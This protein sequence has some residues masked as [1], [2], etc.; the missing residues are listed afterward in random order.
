MVSSISFV[1]KLDRGSFRLCSDEVL[2]LNSMECISKFC[3][4]TIGKLEKWRKL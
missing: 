4:T 1:R 2:D 3:R